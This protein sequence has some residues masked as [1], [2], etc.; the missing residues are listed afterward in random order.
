ME[1]YVFFL[2]LEA[3]TITAANC[4]TSFMHKSSVTCN[5][6]WEQFKM[7][8]D[9]KTIA[10][11]K[12]LFIHMLSS[13]ELLYYLWIRVEKYYICVFCSLSLSISGH[14]TGFG[15]LRSQQRQG[16]GNDHYCEIL[17]LEKIVLCHML[18]CTHVVYHDE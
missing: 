10:F 6:L 8:E 9:R 2:A 12:M 4:K 13:R 17:G 7:L 18:Y 15:S 5:A 3:M 1:S 11:F 14:V 16:T